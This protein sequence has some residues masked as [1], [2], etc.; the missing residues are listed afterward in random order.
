MPAQR[1]RI[2]Y[3]IEVGDFIKPESVTKVRP[4]INLSAD[5]YGYADELV[6]VSLVGAPGKRSFLVVST[7]DGGGPPLPETLRELRDY[8]DHQL[9][10]HSGPDP[11]APCDHKDPS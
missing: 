6:V 5:D 11:L 1:Y 10:H 2:R 7:E 8:I 4:G 3:S 9:E